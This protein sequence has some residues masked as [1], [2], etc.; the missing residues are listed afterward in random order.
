MRTLV[1]TTKGQFLY[2]FTRHLFARAELVDIG[3]IKV[4]DPQLN[5]PS[6]DGFG[7]LKIPGPR[8]KSVLLSGFAKTHHT[9]T[10]P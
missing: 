1:A 8:E 9:Q 4:I 3:G 2:E 5:R 10:Y 7:F 6:E